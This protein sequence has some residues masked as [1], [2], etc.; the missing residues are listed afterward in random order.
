M[1]ELFFHDLDGANVGL[2]EV[3]ADGLDRD[4]SARYPALRELLEVGTPAQ[5]LQSCVMLASWGVRDGLLTL[6]DWALDPDS[7]PWVG[8]PVTYD[9]FFGVDDAFAQLARALDTAR[10]AAL[11]PVGVRLRVGA[12]RA[13]LGIHHHAYFDRWMQALLEADRTLAAAVVPQVHQ[14]AERTIAAARMQ[15]PFDMTTQAALLLVPL[16]ESDDALAASL[17]SQ[18]VALAADWPRTLTEVARAM[19]A[20]HGPGTLYAL[21]QLARSAHPTVAREAQEGLTRR[22]AARG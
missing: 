10:D 19:G 11:T 22:Q 18:L 9:R 2:D 16:A 1:S 14:A 21:Q 13:L 4:Y 8:V 5:R 20:G 15:Q 6:I 3:I 12:T 7:V 17:A